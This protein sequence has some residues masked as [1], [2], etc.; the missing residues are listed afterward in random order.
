M[1][2]VESIITGAIT[3]VGA[4]LGTTIGSYFSNKLVIRHLDEIERKAIER[5]RKRGVV[6]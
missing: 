2:I 1:S 3:G 4:G 6:K 5:R